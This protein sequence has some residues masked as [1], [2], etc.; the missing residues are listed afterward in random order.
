MRYEAKILNQGRS[1][2]RTCI[3]LILWNFAYTELADYAKKRQ[4]QVF[5]EVLSNLCPTDQ[6]GTDATS[7]QDACH[8]SQTYIEGG[9]AGDGRSPS[10]IVLIE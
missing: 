10:S 9:V 8:L 2:Q 5:F 3:H 7:W 6:T 1:Y 4:I